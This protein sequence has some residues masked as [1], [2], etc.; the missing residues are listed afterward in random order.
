[1]YQPAIK[2][3]AIRTLYRIKR[4]YKRPMTEVLEDVLT[5]GL[6]ASDSVKVCS[7]CQQEGNNTDCSSCY[8]GKEGS[9]ER[10]PN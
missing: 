9:Y 5:A 1:V 10:V 8:F 2:D 3:D 4:A 6:R 7:I